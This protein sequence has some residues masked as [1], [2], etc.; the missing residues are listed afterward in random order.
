[1]SLEALCVLFWLISFALLADF[2]AQLVAADSA[3]ADTSDVYYSDCSDSDYY[4]YTKRTMSLAKRDTVDVGSAIVY[5]SF[6][7][8]IVEWYA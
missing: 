8:A 1:M 3:P 7:L 6:A 2:T 5:T 4:C